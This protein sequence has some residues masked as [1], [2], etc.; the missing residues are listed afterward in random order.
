MI[1]DS[2]HRDVAYDIPRIWI[3]GYTA[4]NV[5]LILLERHA[6]IGMHGAI[7]GV[8]LVIG[9]ARPDLWLQTR[10][11]TLGTFLVLFFTWKPAFGAL[12]PTGAGSE[13]VAKAWVVL[14]LVVIVVHA[15]QLLIARRRP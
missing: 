6:H 3:V 9:L 7:L 2:P 11:Y 12:R 14:G 5:A 8:A 15:A 1:E 4:W 10:A 13:S